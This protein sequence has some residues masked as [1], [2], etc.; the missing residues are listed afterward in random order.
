[1]HQ[2]KNM[3]QAMQ[4]DK[5]GK[6]EENAKMRIASVN[7]CICSFLLEVLKVVD[8]SREDCSISK[9]STHSGE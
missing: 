2:E 9:T 3:H 7:K 4:C 8:Y 6:G 5:M 1:M